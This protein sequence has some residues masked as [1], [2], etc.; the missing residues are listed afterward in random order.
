[1]PTHLGLRLLVDGLLEVGDLT[2]EERKQIESQI[3]FKPGKSI[4]QLLA[5][6]GEMISGLSHC[7]GVVL[8]EKQ[9]S[10]LKHIEF[11]PLEPGR[12]LVVMVGDDQ[13]VENRIIS[14]PPGLPPSALVKPRTTSMRTCGDVDRGGARSHREADR[15]CSR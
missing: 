5:E 7:A 4:E 8:A 6:A 12:A 11:V 3:A 10:R 13:T 2:E 14:L 15:Q 1:M 9:V